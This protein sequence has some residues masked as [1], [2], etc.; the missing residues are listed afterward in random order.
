M[1]SL[2]LVLI[3]CLGAALALLA[4]RGAADAPA[5]PVLVI[6]GGAGVLTEKEMAGEK[7]TR[8][9]F[10]AALAEALRTGYEAWKAKDKSSVDAVE[11]AIR[12]M[13]D[14]EL[15]NAGRG[16]ALSH[17]GR[18]ELDAALMEGRMTVRKGEERD[19]KEDPRK[20]AG[21]VAGVV[22]VKNP[23]SAAR[24]VM[25]MK[26]G[27]HVLLAGEGAD[28]FALGEANRRRYR[29]E[30]VS[31]VY[32]WTDRRLRQI[33]QVGREGGG[34]AR[35]RDEVRRHRRRGRAQGRH[36][37]RGHLDR[38]ADEQAPWPHRRLAADRGRHLRR[39]PRLRRLL[40][41]HRRGV[42]PP[43]RRL[44]RRRPHALQ[45]AAGGRGGEG[46]DR[47]LARRGRGRRRADR[48]GQGRGHSF[49]M[50]PRS[51]G[52]YRG[53]VTEAGE[54]YV[55]VFKDDAMKRVEK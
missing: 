55:A 51:V 10:E 4:A 40:H 27:R 12:V 21:A 52:M 37:R 28:T 5:K 50:S 18:A 3:P 17:E 24:A 16:A 42:H 41:R 11:A 14:C 13:E 23:I 8:A 39:R 33:R 31:N 35:R 32:F 6:H 26:G 15:F 29:L 44:R 2:G 48:A 22:R 36:P 25:E 47:R 30:E 34:E 46:D 9:Q 49:A 38:R 19:G 43:R 53:Y 7:L 45:E 1:R 20:R 54:V